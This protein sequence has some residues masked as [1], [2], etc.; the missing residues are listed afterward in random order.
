[1]GVGVGEGVGVGVGV[2]EG[3]GEDE[4]EGEGEDEDAWSKGVARAAA[5]LPV[6]SSR[7]SF[8][9]WKLRVSCRL[10]KASAAAPTNSFTFHLCHTQCGC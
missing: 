1:M 7:A 9:A 5:R 4:G 10:S 3:E 6:A 2:G 8:S